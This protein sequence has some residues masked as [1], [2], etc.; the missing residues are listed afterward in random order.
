MAFLKVGSTPK[1]KTR[2]YVMEI[3]MPTG[4][5]VVKIGKSSGHSSKERMLQICGSIF[6]KYRKTPMIKI[7]RDREV[8]SGVVFKY[9]TILHQFFKNYQ[10]TNGF[11]VDGG[12]E[13]FVID[14]QDAIDS[15]DLVIQG[16]VP[17]K[18]YVRP[19][20]EEE[21]IPF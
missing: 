20:E 17:D 10:Y 3:T 15:Y 2:L 5:T 16:I 7:C 14:T 18:C 8:D 4:I 13:M 21:D 9:E 6:D 11:K 1:I 12:T 19:P